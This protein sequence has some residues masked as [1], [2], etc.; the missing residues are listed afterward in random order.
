MF[1]GDFA[2]LPCSRSLLLVSIRSSVAFR[3]SEDSPISDGFSSPLVDRVFIYFFPR[4]HHHHIVSAH[5]SSPD[6]IKLH[7]TTMGNF[8][9]TTIN[10][11]RQERH[12]QV[13]PPRHFSFFTAVVEETRSSRKKMLKIYYVWNDS[14]G[15]Q[16]AIHY[17][18]M[19]R[20]KTNITEQRALILFGPAP[21]LYHFT[22]SV[23]FTTCIERENV[24][25]ESIRPPRP[26]DVDDDEVS[27]R[28]TTL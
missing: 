12:H 10:P 5:L 25:A 18:F 2:A 15:L 22:R 7:C 19:F 16:P 24:S 27:L 8:T 4:N 3:A 28:W 1:H 6:A 14:I 9:S 17:E 13:T 21:G 23:V 11:H 20:K 26:S